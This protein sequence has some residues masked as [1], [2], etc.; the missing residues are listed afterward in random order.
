MDSDELR[1]VEDVNGSGVALHKHK[2]EVPVLVCCGRDH[3][4]P[5][6]VAGVMIANAHL[7]GRE[8]K[9]GGDDG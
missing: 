5:H 6:G 7:D 2:K 9:D 1:E 4:S 8:A 3:F